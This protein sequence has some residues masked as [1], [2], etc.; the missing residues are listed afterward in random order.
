MGLLIIKQKTML[1]DC[2]HYKAKLIQV[3]TMCWIVTSSPPLNWKGVFRLE[4][5]DGPFQYTREESMKIKFSSLYFCS[6]PDS[7]GIKTNNKCRMILQWTLG[8]TIL[9]CIMGVANAQTDTKPSPPA[10]QTNGC[11]SNVSTYFVPDSWGNCKFKEA[12]NE[13]DKCYSKCLEGGEFHGGAKCNDP[14][15]VKEAR[16]SQCDAELEQNIINNNEGRCEGWAGTYGKAV[17]MAGGG[18]FNGIEPQTIRN[19]IETSDSPEMADSRLNMIENLRQNK[20]VDI[21]TITLT[22]TGD[23]TFDTLAPTLD[24]PGIKDSILV[25]PKDFKSMS[26]DFNSTKSQ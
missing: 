22:P 19:I 7:S 14:G 8:A 4:N 1:N 26:K 21:K 5:F 15:E 3:G 10:L 23:I 6:A 9:F 18:S 2:F 24:R 11:G 16:R 20:F 25:I 12:C 13:H 17:R